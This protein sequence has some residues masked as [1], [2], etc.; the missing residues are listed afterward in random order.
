MCVTAQKPNGQIFE[1]DVVAV[2]EFK[3]VHKCNDR[4]E[5][6]IRC[7]K[8]NRSVKEYSALVLIHLGHR[9]DYVKIC[10]WLWMSSW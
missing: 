3:E 8:L 10:C 4:K 1:L 2:R 6:E 9:F 5:D 7:Y